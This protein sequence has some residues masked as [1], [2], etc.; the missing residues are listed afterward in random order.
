[1]I[2]DVDEERNSLSL[3][4]FIVNRVDGVILLMGVHGVVV[5]VELVVELFAEPVIAESDMLC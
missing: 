5:V 2:V 3:T 1:M 4:F